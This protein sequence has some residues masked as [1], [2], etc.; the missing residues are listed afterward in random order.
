MENQNGMKM[1]EHV[2]QKQK[3]IKKEKRKE[4]RTKNSRIR[5]VCRM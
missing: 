3:C 2:Q 1:N 4:Q 5:N